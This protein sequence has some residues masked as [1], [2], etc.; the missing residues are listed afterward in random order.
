[1]SESIELD[2]SQRLAAA[3]ADKLAALQEAHE[4]QLKLQQQVTPMLDLRCTHRQ[5]V[6]HLLGA[7]ACLYG[8]PAVAVPG[9]ASCWRVEPL[10]IW[11]LQVSEAQQQSSRLAEAEAD[12]ARLVAAF[13]EERQRWESDELV[14]RGQLEEKQQE[15]V[16]SAPKPVWCRNV[17]APAT[18]TSSVAC[19]RL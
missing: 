5:Q 15:L 13:A 4:T 12:K 16:G 6:G 10:W 9:Y 7:S 3:H 1:M 2:V 8:G 11:V 18:G 19:S 14:R 17:Q